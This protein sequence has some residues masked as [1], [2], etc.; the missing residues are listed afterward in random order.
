LS[1]EVIN[2]FTLITDCIEVAQSKRFGGVIVALAEGEGVILP[3]TEFDGVIL[4][5]I[6]GCEVLEG[7]VVTE[8]LPEI[9]T[10]GLK[11]TLI[12]LEIEGL[13]VAEGL[14]LAEGVKDFVFEIE[15]ELLILIEGEE[16]IED[17]SEAVF[18]I[19]AVT[20]TLGLGIGKTKSINA[21]TPL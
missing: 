16:V 5:E 8:T 1:F 4:I 3:V 7:V 17:V 10:E 19:E 21:T 15:L 13:F 9:L 11:V 14:L 2:D 6:V 12:V 18:V 20:L